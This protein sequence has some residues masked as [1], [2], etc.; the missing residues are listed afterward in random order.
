MG[1]FVP[2]FTALYLVMRSRVHSSESAVT[3]AVAEE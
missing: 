1:S 3:E 2:L